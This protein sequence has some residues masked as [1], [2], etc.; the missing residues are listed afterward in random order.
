MSDE[1]LDEVLEDLFEEDEDPVP[2]LEESDEQGEE[3]DQSDA[4]TT[5][6]RLQS[7]G[8]RPRRARFSVRHSA[9]LGGVTEPE[10]GHI[11][12]AL[13]FSEGRGRS[14]NP[15]L[16]AMRDLGVIRK[17]SDQA[18]GHATDVKHVPDVYM[19]NSRRVR[20]ELLAGLLDSDG[21]YT[22]ASNSFGFSQSQRWHE[23]LFWNVAELTCG[24]GF[25]TRSE[26]LVG[27][28][29]YT[30]GT[31]GNALSL[32]FGGDR[33]ADIL[34]LLARKVAEDPLY[35]QQKRVLFDVEPRT[36]DSDS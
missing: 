5:K 20:L 23:K 6:R 16:D 7:R 8:V 19:F 30:E 14:R 11:V 1:M 31:L 34:C 3:D 18:P 12:D 26:L 27:A 32:G 29:E 10:L 21:T 2:G 35:K 28:Y 24:L 25:I 33:V 13:N 4:R 17:A 15:L 36:H 22:P 9:I